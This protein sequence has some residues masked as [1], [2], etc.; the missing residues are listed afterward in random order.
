VESIP[1]LLKSLIIGA[2]DILLQDC[3]GP[4]PPYS[5]VISVQS[6]SILLLLGETSVAYF[7]NIDLEAF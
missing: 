5:A 4:G 1:G 2:L 6:L 7:P 3:L